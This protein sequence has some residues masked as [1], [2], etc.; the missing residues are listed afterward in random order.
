MQING[1][2]LF[3]GI[4]KVEGSQNRETN[5]PSLAVLIYSEVSPFGVNEIAI[6]RELG[7]SSELEAI[8][9]AHGKIVESLLNNTEMGILT[10]GNC[11][12]KSMIVVC[13]PINSSILIP[14]I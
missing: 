11:L 10:D 2:F 13:L 3:S 14:Q 8:V 9:Y 5:W 12:S 1:V 7:F 6:W 4:L